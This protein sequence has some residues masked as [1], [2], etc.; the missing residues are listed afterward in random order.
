[1]SRRPSDPEFL[2]E[3]AAKFKEAIKNHGLTK[4]GA[5]Q[6]LGVTRQ[7]LYLYTHGKVAPGPDVVRRAMELWKIDL[8]YRGHRLTLSNLSAIPSADKEREP[9]QM[10]L[11]DAIK[12][13]DNQSVKIE[14]KDKSTDLIE[15]KV[16]INL[17][18]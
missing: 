16:S 14:I 15:L 10:S 11:W 7:S 17:S 12:K 3:V 9:S 1:M 18:A 13:L 4:K 6:D 2:T 8:T 5:A